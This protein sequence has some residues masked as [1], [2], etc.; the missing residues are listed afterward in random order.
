MQSSNLIVSDMHISFINCV[1]LELTQSCFKNAMLIS[2]NIRSE[3]HLPQRLQNK[4][5]YG[6]KYVH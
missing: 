3:L 2:S 1:N 5:K 6:A 4:S